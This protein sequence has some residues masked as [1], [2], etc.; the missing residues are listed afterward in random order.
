MKTSEFKK[1]IREEVENTLQELSPLSTNGWSN[2]N[3]LQTAVYQHLQNAASALKRKQ[4]SNLKKDIT[5]EIAL[6]KEI[7]AILAMYGFALLKDFNKIY[8]SKN[9]RDYNNTSY[10]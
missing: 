1:L 9:G 3:Y 8:K 6:K 7:D 5:D 2:G 4:E 10:R